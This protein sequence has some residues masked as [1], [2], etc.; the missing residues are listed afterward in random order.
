[1]QFVRHYKRRFFFNPGSVGFAYRHAQDPEKFRADPWAEY[2]V[3]TA[4]DKSMSLEFRRVAFDVVA[5]RS[6]YET[7]GRPHADKAIQQY[8]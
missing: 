1:V 7:S 5:L 6:S 3:L 4:G 8:R 2:A